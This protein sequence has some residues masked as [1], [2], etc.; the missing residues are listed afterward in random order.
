MEIY[1][2]FTKDFFEDASKA[3]RLNKISNKGG[4]FTYKCH[5][6]HSNSRLCNKPI[7]YTIKNKYNDIYCKKHKF[8]ESLDQKVS[9]IHKSHFEE[10]V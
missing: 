2:E 8:K 3:W 4:S 5:Y 9:N 7:Q 10:D 6:K 1:R